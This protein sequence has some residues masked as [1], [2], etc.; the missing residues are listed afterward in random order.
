MSHCFGAV[1]ELR[2]PSVFSNIGQT[3][4]KLNLW[5]PFVKKWVIMMLKR[6]RPWIAVTSNSD[7]VWTIIYEHITKRSVFMLFILFHQPTKENILYKF[8][9]IQQLR[10]Q[11]DQDKNLTR[12]KNPSNVIKMPFVIISGVVSDCCRL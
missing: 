9:V 1:M 11:R 3:I 4:H 2:H 5:S 8:A 10:C 12:S 6:S 7:S